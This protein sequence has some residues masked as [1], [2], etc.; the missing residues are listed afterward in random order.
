MST[1]LF[2]AYQGI[3]IRILTGNSSLAAATWKYNA[4]LGSLCLILAGLAYLGIYRF[5]FGVFGKLLL[6]R[7]LGQKALREILGDH[8]GGGIESRHRIELGPGQPGRGG[9]VLGH[10]APGRPHEPAREGLRGD[11]VATDP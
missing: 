11:H 3:M 7:H 2:V 5:G 4:A 9:T 10:A 8:P 6:G 1:V